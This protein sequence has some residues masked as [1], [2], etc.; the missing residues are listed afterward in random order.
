DF[1]V[2]ELVEGETLATRLK[3]GAFQIADALRCATEMASALDR[4][5]RHGIVHRDLKPANVMLT[6]TGIKLLDFGLAKFTPGPAGHES[7]LP[8]RPADGTA[9]GAILGNLQC[10]SP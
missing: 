7:A 10:K 2:M 6:K 9:E 4:A 5:H 8:T 3:R 1:L